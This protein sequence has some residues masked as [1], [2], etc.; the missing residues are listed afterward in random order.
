MNHSAIMITQ[1]RALLSSLLT[2]VETQED[3]TYANRIYNVSIHEAGPGDAK[4]NASRGTARTSGISRN[5]NSA[6]R[7]MHT[8][9]IEVIS[10]SGRTGDERPLTF[11]LRGLRIDVVEITDRWIEEGFKDR[12]RKR[13]FKIKGSDGTMHRIY[14]DEQEGEWYYRS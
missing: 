12:V 4:S 11:I 6:G 2:P 8:E 9:R 10:Y 3:L 7:V 13:Y 1:P 5:I 14:F